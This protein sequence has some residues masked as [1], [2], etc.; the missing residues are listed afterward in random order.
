MTGQP[1]NAARDMMIIGS[2][3]MVTGAVVPT[4]LGHAF[5]VFDSKVSAY[6]SF[7]LAA[8]T[9]H[10]FSVCLLFFVNPAEEKRR[11]AA[12]EVARA[13]G[14]KGVLTAALLAPQMAEVP[15]GAR[16]CDRLLYHSDHG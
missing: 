1:L 4:I 6:R 8:A 15:I 2:M 10:F 13:A 5:V 16:L 9:I 14:S 12:A 11:A 7:F 3:T